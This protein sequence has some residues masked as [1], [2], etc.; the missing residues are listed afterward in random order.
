[1]LN[2]DTLE[3]GDYL[4]KDEFNLYSKATKFENGVFAFRGW[5]RDDD[6]AIHDDMNLY[7]GMVPNWRIISPGNRY[8]ILKKL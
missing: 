5:H 3:E 7:D 1:M 8:R 6:T 2:I 4:I